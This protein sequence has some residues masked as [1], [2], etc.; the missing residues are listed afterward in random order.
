M[1]LEIKTR[2]MK[3]GETKYKVWST[4]SDSY[5]SKKWW[6]RDEVIQ[7]FFWRKMRTFVRGFVEDAMTFPGGYI[8]K[9][10]DMRAFNTDAE[11]RKEYYELLNDNK[12]Y[13]KFLEEL[14]EVGIEISV[15][16]G[17]YN[18]AN[19]PAGQ[20]FLRALVDNVWSAAMES[21]EVPST[22]WADEIINKTTE[23]FK[24]S[25]KDEEA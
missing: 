1:G 11:K 25:N 15:R 22:V 12:I 19:A 6:S 5:F 13:L 2:V 16:G 8:K 10:S 18:F 14:T 4:I 7:F 9:D 17:E 3:S 23:E 21:A 24:K 20:K